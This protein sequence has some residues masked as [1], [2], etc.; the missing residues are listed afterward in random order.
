MKIQ[1]LPNSLKRLVQ[2]LSTAVKEEGR[3]SPLRS[4][5]IVEASNVSEED[6]MVYADFDHPTKDCYGRKLVFENE[7]FEV[8]V[9]SWNPGH[10]SS[11]H[12]HGYTQWG[13]VQVF[14]DT[15]HMIYNIKDDVLRFSKK[16]IL[17]KGG[18]VKVNNKFIHQ[19]GNAT[20]GRY[21]TLHVYGCNEKMECITADAKNYDLEFDRISHT[22]GG[23]FFNLPASDI[24]DFEEGPKPTKEVFLHYAYL[25]LNYYNRQPQTLEIRELQK[26]IISKI[27]DR[28]LAKK[29]INLSAMDSD[30]IM[31]Q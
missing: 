24:Y 22:T 28:V 26:N 29:K 17:N 21:L 19:M 30:T 4:G 6:L 13:V 27:E 12:N 11:I 5:E 8:M 2:N 15:H 18:V 16:E 31:M 1:T 23:A 10:Y 9:M 3:L 14:G 25:L 7:N 20:T